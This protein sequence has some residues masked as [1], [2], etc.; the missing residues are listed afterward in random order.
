MAKQKRKEWNQMSK[1][2]KT[3]GLI[4]VVII[5]FIGVAII[6][7]IVGAIKGGGADKPQEAVKTEQKKDNAHAPSPETN[8]KNAKPRNKDVSLSESDAEKFCQDDNLTPILTG[9]SEY[10]DVSMID[11][12]NYNKN[13][14][15]TGDYD[16]NG[17]PIMILTWNG[18]RDDSTIGFNCDVS[19]TK[20]NPELHYL[21]MGSETMRGNPDYKTYDK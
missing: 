4:G 18:K 11:V 19:G 17:Y 3:V 7:G 10:S 8:E 9:N 13:Y 6:A 14:V 2:E 15:D 16:K 5:C 1:L 12:W 20:D 21:S